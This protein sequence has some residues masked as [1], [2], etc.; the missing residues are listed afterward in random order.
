MDRNDQFIIIN[1]KNLN[2]KTRGNI[3][4]HNYRCT[5]FSILVSVLLLLWWPTIVTG[6]DRTVTDL[7][8]GGR[9]DVVAVSDAD[10][11]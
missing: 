6:G 2:Y 9:G 8:V 1:K 5:L 7:T 4:I 3:R 10:V 11:A